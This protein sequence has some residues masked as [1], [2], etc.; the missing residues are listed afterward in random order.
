MDY[1]QILGLIHQLPE[2]DIEKLTNVLHSELISKRTS[3][4]IKE[5]LLNAPTWTDKDFNDYQNVRNHIN[6]SRIA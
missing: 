1:N 3:K 6:N 4:S 2:K 5:L